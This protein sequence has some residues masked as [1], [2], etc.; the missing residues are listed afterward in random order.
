MKNLDDICAAMRRATDKNMHT[1]SISLMC[2]PELVGFSS[3][4]Y[5]TALGA[6]DDLHQYHGHMPQHLRDARE[7]L[8]NQILSIITQRHGSHVAEQL[9]QCR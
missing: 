3:R 7:S 1:R 5:L 8:A 2:T 4:L 6:I 9:E